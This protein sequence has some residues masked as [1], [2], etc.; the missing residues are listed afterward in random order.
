MRVQVQK[1]G[2]SLAV[3]IPK[4]FAEDVHV[5]EGTELD[6]SVARQ[7]GGLTCLAKYAD[8]RA[9]FPPTGPTSPPFAFDAELLWLMVQWR[10]DG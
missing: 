3:R 2:N 10:T 9:D 4:P 8:Y 6:L 7:F 1:W 5:R